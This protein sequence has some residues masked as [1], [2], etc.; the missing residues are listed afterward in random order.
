MTHPAFYTQLE[1][2]IMVTYAERPWLKK[3]DAIVPHTL[4]PHPDIPL[5]YYLKEAARKMPN[6]T[7]LITTAKVPVIG[8]Q[9]SRM[10]YLELD[11]LS[12]ALAVGLIEMGLKKGDR[13]AIVMP[14]C[15]AFAISYFGVLKAG[16][17]VAA[18]NPTYPPDK[19]AHQLNDCDAEFVIALTLFYNLLKQVQPQTKVKHVILAN[20]KEYF[21]PI[22]KF[23]FTLAK[24]KK[25]G[26]RVET[27]HS[28]DMW[29]QDVLQKHA[30]QKPNVD[31]RASDIAL[32]QYTGGTTGVSKGAMGA[33]GA[34]VAN[35]RMMQH[36]SGIAQLGNVDG[37]RVE[38]MMYLGAI[39]MFHSYGLIAMLTQATASGSSILLI[40]NPRD[41][42][43]LVDAIHFYKPNV[44]LGVPA[45][46][47][48]I[49]SHPR[50]LSGEVSLTGFLLNTSGAAP[51]PA[52]T[53]QQ[54]EAMAHSV[55]F[56]G[57]GMSE[58]PVATH[59]NPLHGEHRPRSIGLPMP[60]VDC[61]IVSLDDGITD[62]PVGEPGEL[63]ICAPNNMV[64][65]HQ[66]PTETAN[67]LRE[68]EGKTWM[69]TGDVAYMDDD[70]YF[71]I[72][73]RKKDMALIGGFNVY[74]AVVENVIKEHPA[75]FEVAVAA[76]PHPE[77]EGQE[78]LKAWVVKNPNANVTEA[79]LIEHCSKKL[80]PYEVPRRIT[81]IPE[82][83]KTTVGKTLRRELVR[84]EQEIQHNSKQVKQMA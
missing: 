9:T 7:V 26:H 25:D 82:L 4:M 22:A 76:V 61:R 79:E 78:A 66:M 57:F 10:S 17:I 81:F 53:K 55:I 59:N 43:E 38:D 49:G 84:L 40:P 14:N 31:V 46:F 15:V 20:I 68:K 18:T 28:G 24:E 56:E 2:S 32:F 83:P 29:F 62:V 80:A 21:P 69:Y 27:L 13:V 23:L 30:G 44:F 1:E 19:M 50:V 75:V 39:P 45:L 8:R 35:V 5:Q 47:N 33:H 3:Y 65:Y 64:G 36:W 16:G 74:P 58:T 11:Q 54:W 37:H 48:A 63:I 41:M 71:Y 52:A 60:D 34:L 77:K 73:D 72:V 51:L 6:Q 12:D 67:A 42:D 70:G